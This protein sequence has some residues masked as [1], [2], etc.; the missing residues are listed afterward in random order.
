MRNFLQSFLLASFPS[1]DFDNFKVLS[2]FPGGILQFLSPFPGG[3]FQFLSPFL[4]GILVLKYTILLFES[5][6]A[7][8]SVHR[9][10][11][12]PLPD[13]YRYTDQG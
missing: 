13:M 1:S 9:E 4:G 10:V 2:P 5:V 8:L 3:I 12:W 6:S 7:P 11:S